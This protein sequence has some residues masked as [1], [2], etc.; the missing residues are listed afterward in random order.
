MNAVTMTRAL[1]GATRLP[2]SVATPARSP[3]DAGTDAD[4]VIE[5][6]FARRHEAYA[7]YN[8]LPLDSGPVVD[9]HGPHEL[10]LWEIIDAAEHVIR[11]TTAK[12]PRGVMLQ[13][14]CAMYHCVDDTE[15][16]EAVNRGDFAALDN[17]DNDLN[18][19]ARLMLAALRSLQAMEAQAEKG[20]VQ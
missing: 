4:A 6:A 11:T 17:L 18:W 5:A 7:A 14:W 20:A 1:K 10:E 13:L 8:A 16:D 3:A 2:Q 9:G 15:N 19:S 12:T